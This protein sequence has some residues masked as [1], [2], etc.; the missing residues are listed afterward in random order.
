[1]SKKGNANRLRASIERLIAMLDILLSKQDL[2]ADERALIRQCA[3]GLRDL[4]ARLDGLPKDNMREIIELVSVSL[5][6]LIELWFWF[7]SG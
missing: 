1:M 3:N 5:R 2:L 7:A 4:S 6:L